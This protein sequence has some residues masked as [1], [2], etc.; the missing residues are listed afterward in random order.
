MSVFLITL[1][2]CQEC[3]INR[4]IFIGSSSNKCVL[5]CGCITAIG[6]VAIFKQLI[7]CFLYNLSQEVDILEIWLNKH[8]LNPLYALLRV[9]LA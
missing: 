6:V 3:A 9:E 1:L 8:R 2:W 7:L 4:Q 5:S